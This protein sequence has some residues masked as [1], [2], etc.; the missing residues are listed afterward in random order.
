MNAGV[1]HLQVVILTSSREEQNIVQSY[2]PGANDYIR[3]PADFD[4]FMTAVGQLG[5]HWL[6]LN[7][8]PL[9]LGGAA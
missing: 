7:E 9:G 5:L 1:I 4:E 3:K 2:A 6:L 8:R